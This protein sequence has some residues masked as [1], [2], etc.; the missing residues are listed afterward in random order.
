MNGTTSP[1]E[2]RPDAKTIAA[3]IGTVIFLLLISTIIYTFTHEGGHALLGWLFGGNITGFSINFIDFSAHV[4]LDGTFLP[5]QRALI[6]IAGVSLPVLVCLALLALTAGRKEII[7]YYFK[8]IFALISINA[9]LAWITIPVLVMFGLT[10]GDDSYVFLTITRIPPLK[11]TGGA[12]IVYVACI[13]IFLRLMGGF[14][15]F[16]SRFR[17]ATIDLR[18]PAARKSLI[19]LGAVGAIILASA[20]GLSLSN[21]PKAFTSLAGYQQV[22]G[23]DLADHAL[24]AQSVYQFSLEVP[25]SVS[26]YILLDHIEGAPV[27]V[28]L[29]GPQGYEMVFLDMT[30]PQTSIGQASVNPQELALDPGD[31]QVLVTLPACKGTIKLFSREEGG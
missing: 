24:S 15:F 12:L 28:R 31:Y 21:P 2:I 11:E 20:Y 9:V 29:V 5:W 1:T 30:D 13:V 19:S 25:T 7:F 18:Q 4:G 16:V 22:A 23:L 3:S 26:L 6:T 14:A 17:T 27:N 10:P 8:T